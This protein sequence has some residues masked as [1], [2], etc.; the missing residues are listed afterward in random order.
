MRY[1]NKGLLYINMAGLC[2]MDV[3]PV[4]ILFLEANQM[5]LHCA[6]NDLCVSHRKMVYL[7]ISRNGKQIQWFC[8]V[9]RSCCLAYLQF[10]SRPQFLPSRCY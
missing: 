7:P 1:Q 4:I 8:L 5:L 9:S 10:Q 6:Q 2:N 3:N